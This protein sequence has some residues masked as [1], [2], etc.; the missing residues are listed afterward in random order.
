MAHGNL[1]V[2]L[3]Q[4]LHEEVAVL[5]VHNGFNAG[6]QNLYAVLLQDAALVELRTAVQRRLATKGQKNAVG[7]LL[8][9]DFCDEVRGYWLKI[10]LVCYAFRSL[11]S[12]DVGVN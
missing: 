12:S 4:L 10:H 11:D 5:S 9:D 8:L 6:S 1:Q 3:G 7:A 2:D